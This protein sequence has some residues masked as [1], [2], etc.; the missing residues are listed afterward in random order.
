[1]RRGSM[2]FGN[3]SAT[4][5]YQPKARGGDEAVQR[6]DHGGIHQ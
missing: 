1:M 4:M 3:C 2:T 5:G 6:E